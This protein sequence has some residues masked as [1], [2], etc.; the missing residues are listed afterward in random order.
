VTHFSN[1]LQSGIYYTIAVKYSKTSYGIKAGTI[2]NCS[3]ILEK[4]LALFSKRQGLYM[5]GR[6]SD[7]SN[8]RYQQKTKQ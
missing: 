4:E 6:C 8:Q 3:L 1:L 5:D 7:Q 2:K